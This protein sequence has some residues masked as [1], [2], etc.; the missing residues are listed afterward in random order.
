MEASGLPAQLGEPPAQSHQEEAPVLEEFG[1]FLFVEVTD[2]LED[3]AHQEERGGPGPQ[4]VRREANHRQQQR[5]RDHRD[6]DRVAG[7]IDGV[8]VAGGVLRHPLFRGPVAQHADS[9]IA[10]GGTFASAAFSSTCAGVF[11]P[12]RAQEIPSMLRANCKAR[13]ASVSR[14]LSESR[15]GCGSFCVSRPC[16]TL[17]EAK[18]IKC[19]ARAASSSVRSR[20]LRSVA[21]S[22]ISRLKGSCRARKWWPFPATAWAASRTSCSERYSSS[23]GSSR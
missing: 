23:P 15:S 22:S 14:P 12:T 21:A 20:W 8:R 11:M 5:E 10:S 6:A 1:G 7:S 2:E 16:R 19:A 17:A 4:S 9:Y 18:T 3:P 13:C